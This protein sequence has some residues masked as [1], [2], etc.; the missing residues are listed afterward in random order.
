LSDEDIPNLVLYCPF[1]TRLTL[2]GRSPQKKKNRNFFHS[3]K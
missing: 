2:S 1:I 3:R